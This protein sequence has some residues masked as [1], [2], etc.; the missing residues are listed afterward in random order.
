MLTSLDILYLSLSLGFLVLVWF[1]SYTLL[2][3]AKTMK[4]L[5]PLLEDIRDIAE[6]IRSAKD[7]VKNG[8]NQV[9][10][11]VSSIIESKTKK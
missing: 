7:G 3:V 2:Q 1:L 5:H 6:D 8:F 11:I 9:A 4:E 10:N